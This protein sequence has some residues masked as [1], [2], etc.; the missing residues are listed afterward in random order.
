MVQAGH[1]NNQVPTSLK[2]IR[3]ILRI[4]SSISPKLAGFFVYQI[5]TTPAKRHRKKLNHNLETIT[6]DHNGHTLVGY[7]WRGTGRRVLL[8]HGWESSAAFFRN[9]IDLLV[10]LD[11]HVLAM[12]A[13]AH[14]NSKGRQTNPMDYANALNQFITTVGRVDMVIAHSLGGA[15][16][17]NLLR[18]YPEIG[19]EKVVLVGAV[20]SPQEAVE[21][22]TELFEISQEVADYLAYFMVKNVGLSFEEVSSVRIAKSRQEPA[23]IIHDVDDQTVPVSSGRAIATAWDGAQYI[24]TQ[25]LGHYRIMKDKSILNQILDFIT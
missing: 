14:G 24:E 8:V 11:Y 6:I 5:F 12:D 1:S 3:L 16:T 18:V 21:F 2:I 9:L 7:E 25:G 13:P 19:I 17:M 20:D 15:A 4:A 23:L 10:D 22:F